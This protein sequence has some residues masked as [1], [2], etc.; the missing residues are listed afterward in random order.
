MIDATAQD[1]F[2]SVAAA[3]LQAGVRSV[4]AMSYSLYVSAARVFLPEFYRRFFVSEH[5]QQRVC[6][7][8]D[9]GMNWSVVLP[10]R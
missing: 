3:L 10:V 7:Q 4:M 5:W 1:A 8:R 9:G 6:V 2:A